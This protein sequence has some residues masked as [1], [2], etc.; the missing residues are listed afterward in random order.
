MKGPRY[1]PSRR[2]LFSGKA[3]TEIICSTT[4]QCSNKGRPRVDSDST[5]A[6]TDSRCHQV[7]KRELNQGS[8]KQL[9]LLHTT[10]VGK[11]ARAITRNHNNIMRWVL[12]LHPF[13]LQNRKPRR[14][15]H[16]AIVKGHTILCWELG[17]KLGI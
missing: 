2:L 15:G 4:R 1:L 13:I 5:E 11:C 12:L 9:A 6:R 8:L 14:R 10:T 7:H 17:S 16:A 3:N